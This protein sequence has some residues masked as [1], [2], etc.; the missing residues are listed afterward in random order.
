MKASFYIENQ[1]VLDRLIYAYQKNSIN[2]IT[3]TSWVGKTTL[4]R[5]HAG[6]AV[7]KQGVVQ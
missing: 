1:K 7:L 4:Q 6:F 5:A 3:A 2:A